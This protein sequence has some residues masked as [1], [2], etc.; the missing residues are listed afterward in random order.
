V[1][2]PEWRHE[3]A[4][5]ANRASRSLEVQATR[6]INCLTNLTPEEAARTASGPTA[7]LL[8]QVRAL[9]PTSTETGAET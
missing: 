8:A 4:V 1:S 2:D 7:E 6:L 5:K 9:L 3:R